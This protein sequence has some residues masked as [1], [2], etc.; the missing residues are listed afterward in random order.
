[1]TLNLT[2]EQFVELC[3]LFGCDYCPNI[4]DIKF[5]QIYQTYMKHK[6]MDKTLAELSKE[7]EFN[8][9]EYYEA[10]QYFI[11]TSYNIIEEP[12]TLKEPNYNKLVELLVNKY[13]LIKYKVVIKLQSLQH[14]YL[15]LKDI[16]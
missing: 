1:M 2:Y 10:K 9:L 4:M 13:G 5:T 8:I 16:K 6:S 12:F 15:Q 3:I 11:N 14:Y 7:Y